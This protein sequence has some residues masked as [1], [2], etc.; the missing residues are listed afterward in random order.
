MK[1]FDEQFWNTDIDGRV[2][3]RVIT[4][5]SIFILALMT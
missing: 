1:G 5:I 3:I 2:S 4:H